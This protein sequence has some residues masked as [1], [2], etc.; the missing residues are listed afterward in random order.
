MLKFFRCPL[1]PIDSPLKSFLGAFPLECVGV[2][3]C[4]TFDD[5]LAILAVLGLPMVSQ[6][7]PF[8]VVGSA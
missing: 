6:L 1:S 3:F 4:D 7:L 2:G 5:S 8:G